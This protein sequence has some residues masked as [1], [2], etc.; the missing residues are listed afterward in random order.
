MDEEKV[1]IPAVSSSDTLAKKVCVNCN[2][3]QGINYCIMYRNFQ[4]FQM[5]SCIGTRY[6]GHNSGYI[7]LNVANFAEKKLKKHQVIYLH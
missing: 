3:I 5:E 6:F 4:W 2:F 7:S 1:D